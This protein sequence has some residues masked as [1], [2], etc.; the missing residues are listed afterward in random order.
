MS[1]QLKRVFRV[2]LFSAILS[3]IAIF[4]MWDHSRVNMDFQELKALLAAVRSQAVRRH[5]VLVAWFTGKTLSI[6]DH[7]TGAVIKTLGF[8]TL[9]QVN[10]DTT[11]GKDM[12]VFY[13][14]GT[15]KYNE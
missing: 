2:A 11:L 4:I 13:D 1:G 3:G 7:G 10:Y 9:N 6:T 15:E 14:R 5:K 8:P 12:I